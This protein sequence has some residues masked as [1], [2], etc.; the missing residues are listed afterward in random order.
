M[1]KQLKRKNNNKK[2]SLKKV[3]DYAIKNV[4]FCFKDIT[5]NNDYSFKKLDKNQKS[6]LLDRIVELSSKNW[7]DLNSEGKNIAYETLIKN[8]IS[9]KP[10]CQMDSK[11]KYYVFRCKSPNGKDGRIVGLRRN[12]CYKVL[13]VDFSYKLYGH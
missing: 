7:V 8:E 12:S 13:F 4:V 2:T 9:I 10:K 3:A 5:I 6:C 1:S 11:E